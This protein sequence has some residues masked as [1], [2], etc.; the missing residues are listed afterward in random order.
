MVRCQ[1]K[2]ITAKGVIEIRNGSC[3]VRS[4]DER[5]FPSL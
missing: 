4:I 5:N 1:S 2:E 3:G